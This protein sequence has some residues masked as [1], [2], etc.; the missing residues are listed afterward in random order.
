MKEK[1]NKVALKMRGQE[2]TAQE[3][4]NAI[5]FNSRFKTKDELLVFITIFHSKSPNQTIKAMEA[6]K[7]VTA[8]KGGHARVAKDPKQKDKELVFECWQA[9]QNK[10]ENYKSKA[11]FAR[12]MLEKSSNLVSQKIIEDWC[13][14]WGKAHPAS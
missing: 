11:A 10:P 3:I 14:D 1:L 9:W 8:S 7:I 2:L 13:R 5:L 4:D 12:D 6:Q